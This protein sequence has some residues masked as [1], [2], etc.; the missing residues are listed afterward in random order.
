MVKVE[1]INP[2]SC[3]RITPK[4]ATAAEWANGAN[5]IRIKEKAVVLLDEISTADTSVQNAALSLVLDR[6]AGEYE[7][8]DACRVV[9]A[10]NTEEDGAFVNPISFALANRFLHLTLRPSVPVFL[11]YAME[12]R[13][14]PIMISFINMWG[15]EYLHRYRADSQK[16]G[17]Y[18]APTPRSWEMWCQQYDAEH[19]LWKRKATTFGLLGVDTGNRLLGFLSMTTGR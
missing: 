13:L 18:G 10:G 12:N 19:P 15:A 1:V 6:R 5:A 16:G 3:I 9:A 8:N 7:L 4:S 11:Q 14:N 2:K 17:D